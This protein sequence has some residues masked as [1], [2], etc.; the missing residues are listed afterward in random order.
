MAEEYPIWIRQ[1]GKETIER[2]VSREAT[3]GQIVRALI[4]ERS[5]LCPRTVWHLTFHGETL[6]S[7]TTME[8]AGVGAGAEV[9]LVGEPGHLIFI[10]QEGELE[11]SFTIVS[12]DT[13]AGQVVSLSFEERD[14][15]QP[16][17]SWHLTFRGET[18]S[19]EIIM[20]EAGIRGYDNVGLVSQ[21][22]E[23][24]EAEYSI[25]IHQEGH[26]E[27]FPMDV[28]PDA[29][30]GQ[31]VSQFIEERDLPH[32]RTS[33]H[34]TFHGETLSDD[35]TLADAGISADFHLDLVPRKIKWNYARLEEEEPIFKV[36]Y[37]HPDIQGEDEKGE[38][39]PA[40]VMFLQYVR[41][42]VPPSRRRILWRG[43]SK[44]GA[45]AEFRI[46][47]MSNVDE[48]Y[49][50]FDASKRSLRGNSSW[51]TSNRTQMQTLPFH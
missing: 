36:R 12:R 31:V 48:Q 17:G 37:Q 10:H 50:R 28:S 9:C 41:N 8:E 39:M 18:L 49:F 23:K 14:L 15:V 21:E 11:A 33:W 46:V 32:L 1:E 3:A 35:M 16:R 19:D 5:L 47:F 20:E 27:P 25:F 51:R 6:S 24:E 29:T 2:E 38:Y 13:T 44:G 30:A 42:P 7:E 40:L 22:L 43:K 45:K 34:L 26:L 4:I